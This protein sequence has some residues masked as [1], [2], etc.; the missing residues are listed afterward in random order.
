MNQYNKDFY[1]LI[2]DGALRSAWV[3]APKVYEIFN[4]KSV[5]DF[6]CGTG[7]WLSVFRDL[8]ATDI[9]GLDGSPEGHQLIAPE[10]FECIDLGNT[11][12]P[13][14]KYDLAISLEVAEHLPPH[15]AD[16]FVQNVTACSD[17]ILWSAAVPR[18]NG[19]GHI[20]E[21]W[22]SYWVP[23]FQ[24]RGYKCYSTFRFQFWHDE[25][26]ENWYRQNVLLF[27]KQKNLLF[28]VPEILD[29]IHYNNWT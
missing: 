17:N 13:H 19:V 20:N 23:K 24:E 16:T 12:H 2:G 6:G 29:V 22:P 18:Q 9:R 11:Y 3:V 15:C 28:D 1:D 5:I 7:A 14:Q 4:P 10:E 26:V 25:N 27:S 21:Q 8:G